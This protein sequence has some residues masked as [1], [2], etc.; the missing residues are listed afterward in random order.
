MRDRTEKEG[1]RALKEGTGPPASTHEIRG[2]EENQPHGIAGHRLAHTVHLN[3]LLHNLEEG[4]LLLDAAHHIVYVNPAGAALLQRPDQEL[5]GVAL[6]TVLEAAADDP[7]LKALGDL[8]S[9]VELTTER[10]D[11]TYGE[12]TF[13]ITMTKLLGEGGDTSTLLLIHDISG[14]LRRV[15][16]LAALNELSSL[17]TSTLDVNQVLR[18]IME[19]IHDLMGV[20]ASSLLLKDEQTDELVFRVALGE[21]SAAVVGRRLKVG[22]GIAGWVFEHGSPLVVPDVREDSRFYQGVDYDTGFTTKSV[23]CVPLSPREKVIGV[24]QIL[25]G[26]T[27][28]AFTQDDVNLLSAIAAHA[29][30]AIE[31]ARLFHQT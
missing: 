13:H 19:R 26:P 27:D 10:L 17:L 14:S 30:T 25:N 11:Y 18:L 20:E 7:L 1:D 28:R 4:V 21:Y 24:I 22:Q 31:N 6:S 3:A 29:A 5:V 8:A 15:R 2:P 12:L 9:Q 16:E 23:L